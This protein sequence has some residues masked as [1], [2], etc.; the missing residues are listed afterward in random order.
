MFP[1]LGSSVGEM[2]FKSSLSQQHTLLLGCIIH[3]IPPFI[4]YVALHQT[5][6][7]ASLTQKSSVSAVRIAVIG[8]DTTPTWLQVWMWR[9]RVA[10]WVA[11]AIPLAEARV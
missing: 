4:I 1:G 7:H 11:A 3:G 9:Q 8:V 10:V 6:S 2:Q 5:L